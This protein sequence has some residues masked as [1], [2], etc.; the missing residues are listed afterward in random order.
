M[1]I[2]VRGEELILDKER[3][4]YFPQQQLLAISDLHLGKAA[5]FRKAGLQV[6]STMA[7]DDLD[8]LARLVDHYQPKTLLVN[9]DMLHSDLNTD[10][11]EFHQWK[12]QYSAVKFLL[13]KGNHDKLKQQQYHDLGI[14]VKD[15][16]HCTDHFCFIH[17]SL[18]CNEKALY[19]ISG[20]VHPGISITGR[21]K[22]RLKFPCFYFGNEYAIMPAFS[23]FTGL[24][25]IN[26]KAGEQVFAITPNKVIAI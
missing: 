15:P 26:P 2:T 21:A 25:L 23:T 9:G 3:A 22:Q 20:H 11:T 12:Q 24:Y 13:V 18:H 17:D 10:V 4:I 16:S 6:P 19:P 5:H 14:M 8:R 1:K 7:K